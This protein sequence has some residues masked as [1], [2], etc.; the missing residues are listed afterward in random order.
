MSPVI[1]A[2]KKLGEAVNIVKPFIECPAYRVTMVRKR[3]L[4][5]AS[6]RYVGGIKK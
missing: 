1:T 2:H 3:G 4:W 6:V 5:R